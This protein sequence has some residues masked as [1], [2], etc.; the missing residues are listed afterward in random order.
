MTLVGHYDG[1]GELNKR[2]DRAKEEISR[3]H[4]KD[5]KVYPFERHVTK[6]NG[7]QRVHVLMKEIKLT[8]PCVIAVKTDVYKDYRADSIAATNSLSGLISN[9]HSGAQMNYANR[10]SNKRR[11][12]SSLD[13]SDSR[14]G[15]GRA[16]RGGGR[17][18]NQYGSGGRGRRGGRV[19]RGRGNEP[20]H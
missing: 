18:G 9:L 13:S 6:L 7:K 1:T 8:D 10:H 12:V 3:L 16:K 17:H 19:G 5:K 15:R 14:G 20:G 11:Y 4:Y 2:V